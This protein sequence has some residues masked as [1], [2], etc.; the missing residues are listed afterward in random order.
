MTTG[1]WTA[2]GLGIAVVVG[3]V[4]ACVGDDPETD[5][6]TGNESPGE[7]FGRCYPN[8]TC[9]EG[10]FCREGRF[11]LTEN[12]PVPPGLDSGTDGSASDGGGEAGAEGGPCPTTVPQPVPGALCGTTQCAPSYP[13]CIAPSG[14]SAMCVEDAA[15]CTSIRWGCNASTDCS[16]GVCCGLLRPRGGAGCF[17]HENFDAGAASCEPAGFECNSLGRVRLCTM[18]TECVEDQDTRCR[19]AHVYLAASSTPITVG[20]CAK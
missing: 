19:P 11:C 13:C 14:A 20:I 17:A 15:S 4:F 2:L 9:N 8:G 12:E 16:T 5:G 18:D 7:R 10:L 3:G 6:P 1:R